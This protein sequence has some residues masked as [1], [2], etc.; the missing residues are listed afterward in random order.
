[1]SSDS[2]LA[3]GSGKF[4]L[5][6]YNRS[7]SSWERE[8]SLMFGFLKGLSAPQYRTKI[9]HKHHRRRCWKL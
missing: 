5:T 8:T 4:P 7:L 1:M 2:E 3:K 6:F 9:C